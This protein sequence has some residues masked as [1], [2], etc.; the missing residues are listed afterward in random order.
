VFIV[1]LRKQHPSNREDLNMILEKAN[2]DSNNLHSALTKHTRENS[3][4]R[5]LHSFVGNKMA[6]YM[7]YLEAIIRCPKE[8]S[9]AKNIYEEELDFAQSQIGFI[10]AQEINLQ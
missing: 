7:H 3:S 8:A 1:W 2:A 4:L 10:L 9:Q 6:G 5:A